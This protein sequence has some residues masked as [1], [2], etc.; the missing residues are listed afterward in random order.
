MSQSCSNFYYKSPTAIPN[1][2][3]INE[4]KCLGI[5]MTL[6]DTKT[7][8][9]NPG[10]THVNCTTM[11]YNKIYTGDF[12]SYNQVGFTEVMEDF[13]YLFSSYLS[14]LSSSNKGGHTI[15]V[16]GQ[17]GYDDF[18]NT[19]ISACSNNPEYQLYG[20]CMIAA[21]NVCST[22]TVDNIT[23][24]T[25]LL[26]LCGCQVSSLPKID[27]YSKVP[28]A[29]DPLCIHEQIS[30]K[31]DIVTGDP[32]IC[33]ANVCVINNIA[34]SASESTVGGTQFTQ[35]C[36]SCTSTQSCICIV[37]STIPGIGATVGLNGPNTFTQY[38]GANSVCLTLDNKTQTS[39]TVPCQSVTEPPKAE[40]Y[41]FPIPMWVWYVIIGVFII[42]ILVL[43]AATQAGN[44]QKIVV[45][46]KPS[47]EGGPSHNSNS[48]SNSN[49]SS[50]NSHHFGNS[51]GTSQQSSNSSGNY[52]N[53]SKS[54]NSSANSHHFGNSQ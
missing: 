41:W 32:E 1:R 19:L 49:N 46:K 15:G 36:P 47:N 16:A 43:I 17:T 11:F 31:R 30:K 26:R 9:R 44:D 22:C 37:D 2:T 7:Y 52:H 4:Q 28:A 42:F 54:N 8:W 21:K 5:G 3:D 20:A 25:D 38:C 33:N 40:T 48:S 39:T 34:I 27:Q 45:I 14:P 29:C 12:H 13:N 50:G 51:S 18:Q 10:N 23:S 35:I 53:S 24:N 6:E